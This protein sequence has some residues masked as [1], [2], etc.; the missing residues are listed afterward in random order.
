MKKSI[1]SWRVDLF[2]HSSSVKQKKPLLQQ[3]KASNR[4]NLRYI[5]DCVLGGTIQSKSNRTTWWPKE[6]EGGVEAADCVLFFVQ[7][8]SKSPVREAGW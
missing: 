6:E 2:Y 8:I 3:S 5:W 1:S 4:S 7:G